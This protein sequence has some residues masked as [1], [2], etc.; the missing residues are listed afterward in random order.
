MS[1][2]PQKLIMLRGI[3]DELALQKLVRSKVKKVYIL[4]GRPNLDASQFAVKALNERGIKPVLISDNMAGFL[5]AKGLVKEV[6][7]SYQMVDQKGAVCRI[8]ALIL[9]VLAK[10]HKVPVYLFKSGVKVKFMGKPQELF[11]F[12]GE[13]IAPKGIRAYV[14]QVEWVPQRYIT[15]RYE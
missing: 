11:F 3:F 12:L 6:W 8:G 15:K 13:R 14:P 5:F 10:K 4:E 2:K 7:L 1:I 9:A